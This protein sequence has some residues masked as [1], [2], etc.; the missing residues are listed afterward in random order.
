MTVA[1]TITEMAASIT[2]AALVGKQLPDLM[3]L[4]AAALDLNASHSA[5]LDLTDLDAAIDVATGA[6]SSATPN[7]LVQAT[8]AHKPVAVAETKDGV[9]HSVTLPVNSVHE[10]HIKEGDNV[11]F[12][13]ETGQ[14]ESANFYLNDHHIESLST[15][16]RF[17]CHS[18]SMGPNDEYIVHLFKLQPSA[19]SSTTTVYLRVE[20]RFTGEVFNITKT[21]SYGSSVSSANIRA[22]RKINANKFALIIAPISGN[23]LT[24][25]IFDFVDI[26]TAATGT[27]T[28]NGSTGVNIVPILVD[29][30]NEVYTDSLVMAD[31]N[32][33]VLTPNSNAD[34]F[35]TTID[36]DAYTK[37]RTTIAMDHFITS[38]AGQTHD[39]W[40]KETPAGNIAVVDLARNVH[41]YE[42]TA[43]AINATP[44]IS[45]SEASNIPSSGTFGIWMHSGYL[46]VATSDAA[47]EVNRYLLDEVG[48]TLTFDSVATFPQLQTLSGRLLHVTPRGLV[49]RELAEQVAPAGL[50]E[51]D[52]V[53]GISADSKLIVGESS[54]NTMSS[55]KSFYPDGS[56]P[57]DY[58]SEEDDFEVSAM[59]RLDRLLEMWGL[60]YDIIQHIGIAASDASGGNV[61]VN[62]YHPIE[63]VVN[64]GNRVQGGLVYAG[65]IR[66]KPQSPTFGKGPR[67]VLRA[68]ANYR[69]DGFDISSGKTYAFLQAAVADGFVYATAVDDY[70]NSNNYMWVLVDG[71]ITRVIYFDQVSPVLNIPLTRGVEYSSKF[72]F[73]ASVYGTSNQ[74]DEYVNDSEI[75]ETFL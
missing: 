72:S 13:A 64:T 1:N 23:D 66:F 16:L 55:F 73:S 49:L 65:N 10:P 47:I 52:S 24:V 63:S 15:S 26:T 34:S 67:V 45:Q 4:R 43:G 32:L 3:K 29:S 12:N 60:K 39:T 56:I 70:A 25:H 30:G 20:N 53:G 31:G 50:I 6:L 51:Y 75:K 2:A 42:Y 18:L 74:L 33:V 69:R 38:Y 7:E 17:K 14:V 71:F 27:T 61:T 59:G 21:I 57:C 58:Y 19:A 46:S 54:D 48:D 9:L 40:M 44:K 8:A 62:A 28:I 41:V 36:T 68:V 35:L 11:V 22:M 5:G 37:V